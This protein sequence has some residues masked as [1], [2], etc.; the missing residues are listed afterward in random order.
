MSEQ[1]NPTEKL[2][3]YI[4]G[5]TEQQINSVLAY[6]GDKPA[7]EVVHLINALKSPIKVDEVVDQ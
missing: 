7:K 1:E 6:L 2:K 5:Y 3:R 4:Y